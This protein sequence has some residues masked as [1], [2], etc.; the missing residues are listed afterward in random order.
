VVKSAN[1]ATMGRENFDD[2]SVL[3]C[4]G[5]VKRPLPLKRLLRWS[6]FNRTFERR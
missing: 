5:N 3:P 6:G 1:A 2:M 4:E